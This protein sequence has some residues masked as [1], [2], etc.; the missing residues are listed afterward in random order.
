MYGRRLRGVFLRDFLICLAPLASVDSVVVGYAEETAYLIV[1]HLLG[2]VPGRWIALAKRVAEPVLA[3]HGTRIAAGHLRTRRRSTVVGADGQLLRQD[4]EAG[5]STGLA[6]QTCGA[7]LRANASRRRLRRYWSHSDLVARV[8][9][10]RDAVDAQQDEQ[11]R[12]PGNGKTV[13]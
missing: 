7:Q 6:A 5:F 1:V 2:T 12:H 3:E 9:G 10:L 13:L 11:Y 4:M 8:T